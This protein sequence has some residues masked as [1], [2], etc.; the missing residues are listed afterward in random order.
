MTWTPI[1]LHALIQIMF[2]IQKSAVTFRNNSNFCLTFRT[3]PNL[4]IYI[5]YLRR[6]TN[7]RFYI[8]LNNFAILYVSR[9][10][11]LHYTRLYEKQQYFVFQINSFLFPLE[12]TFFWDHSSK[13]LSI[14]LRVSR[15]LYIAYRSCWAN[16]E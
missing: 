9:E 16:T 11:I 5:K 14:M 12:A 7:R 2:L 15:L 13:C 10:Q 8:A 3:V 1:H 4:Q 6:R